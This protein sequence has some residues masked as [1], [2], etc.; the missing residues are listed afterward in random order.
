MT[1]MLAVLAVAGATALVA[2]PAGA[3]ERRADGVRN[4]DSIEISAQRRYYRRHYYGR[5]YARPYWGSRYYYGRPYYPYYEPY[6][7][8]GY[9]PYGYYRPYRYYRPGAF[10]GIG[11]FGIGFGW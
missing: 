3:A 4:V 2:L 9:Y 1:R 10:V 11:P 5:P 6:Y 7:A 8:Y